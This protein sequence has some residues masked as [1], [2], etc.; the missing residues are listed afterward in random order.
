MACLGWSKPGPEMGKVM[1]AVLEW[2]LV[3]PRVTLQQ[4][5]ERAVQRFGRSGGGG[6][7]GS[8]A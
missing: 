4:C 1:A 6:G 8:G 2:Q 3:D 5:Q 7:G